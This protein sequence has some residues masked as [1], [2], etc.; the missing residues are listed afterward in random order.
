MIRRKAIKQ[1]AYII[2]LSYI[3][4]QAYVNL[5][6]I[7]K[8]NRGIC[9]PR[10]KIENDRYNVYKTRKILYNINVRG[11]REHLE[12]IYKSFL[13]KNYKNSNIF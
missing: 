10:K 8:M 3:L 2:R 6:K 11:T 1:R 9:I 7:S 12:K 5:E 13:E 4:C